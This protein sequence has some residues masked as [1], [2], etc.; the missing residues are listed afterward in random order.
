[1]IY[2]TITNFI[3]G[4]KII[5]NKVKKGDDSLDKNDKFKLLEALKED[6]HT[7]DDLATRFSRHKSTIR[8][9][10][11]DL[12]QEGYKI[13]KHLPENGRKVNF[14]YE[15]SLLEIVEN[16]SFSPPYTDYDHPEEIP[17]SN[18][19]NYAIGFVNTLFAGGRTNKKLFKNFLKYAEATSLD[20]VLITGNTLWMDL[21]RYSKY[22]PDRASNSDADLDHRLINYPD[23]VVKSGKDPKKLLEENKPVYITFKERLD[24]VIE[25][26]LKPLFLE[27]NSPIYNGNIY[28]TLGDM[29]EELARQ[30]TN[31]LVRVARNKELEA[32]NGKLREL[33]DTVK[34]YAKMITSLQREHSKLTK[35]VKD[36]DDTFIE[37]VTELEDDI[38]EIRSKRDEVF[39][40]IDQWEEYR[41][42]I[43]MTNTSENFIKVASSQMLGYIINRIESA[44]PNS[45]VVSTGEA[46][47]KINDKVGKIIPVA[48]KLSGKPSDTLMTRLKRKI[49]SEL[50]QGAP[51][52]DFVVAGGLSPERS[53]EY[54]PIRQL[55]GPKTITVIQLPTCIDSA[56]CELKSKNKVRIAGDDLAKLAQHPDFKSGAVVL[57]YINDILTA[58]NL[59][60]EYL[61]NDD[62]F[63]DPESIKS[64]K[65][66]D[67]AVF[68]DQHWGSRYMS[69]TEK[70][71]NIVPTY[72]VAQ[73]LLRD[74]KAPLVAIFSLGDELQ[75]K[76]YATETEP[77]PDILTPSQIELIVDEIDKIEDPQ[78]KSIRMKKLIMRQTLRSGL[79]MP[80]SQLHEYLN[81]LDYDLIVE[82]IKR[83]DKV[84]LYGPAYLIVNGNHNAHTTFGM[85]TTSQLI[86]R[87]V[88]LRM[89]AKNEEVVME[90][91]LMQRIMAPMFGSEGLYTGLWG[92]APSVSHGDLLDQKES[93]EVALKQN[94]DYLYALYARHKQRSSKTGDNMKGSR[95]AFNS[96]GQAFRLTDNRD[97]L[98]LSAHDH[99]A[100]ETSAKHGEHLR[101]MCFME[102]NSFG[103]KLDY[104]APTIGFHVLRM[105]VGGYSAGP[106]ITID[107]PIEKIQQY[108]QN[109]LE[110]NTEELFHNSIVFYDKD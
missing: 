34:G 95:D 58:E 89:G 96:R 63:K 6:K 73:E 49:S 46:Y 84:G 44:I 86:A 28:L 68:G 27:N 33:K 91:K 77:H 56:A 43:L 30:H 14:S 35:S 24:M 1:M 3:S 72:K 17:V 20:A 41:S 74:I 85:Y 97:Y 76:N 101:S 94:N 92:V 60:E 105:P 108:A 29:E 16:E 22:K 9:W 13:S 93:L 48:N 104:G 32:V 15:P 52:V 55:E 67:A 2:L 106:V 79:L 62:M 37:E 25:K 47:I 51:V 21:T 50:H 53:R 102:R 90:E 81:N 39:K 110:V 88:R 36:S 75:E 83:A 54:T 71:D 103:E 100:G 107:F 4:V 99:M 57:R 23:A 59:R 11:N 12:R 5:K 19:D 42:R 18:P 98:V 10:I 64:F 65:L 80:M 87:E 66:M 26:S 38:D 40:E 8:R 78:E 82:T 69:L 61:T 70:V 45:K 31:E 7:L 109:K